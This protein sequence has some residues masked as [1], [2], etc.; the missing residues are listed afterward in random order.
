MS[1]T[2]PNPPNLATTITFEL[3]P[4]EDDDGWR[5]AA[6]FPGGR[7]EY[8]TGFMNRQ[9]AVDWMSSPQCLEWARARGH[10]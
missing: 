1:A 7:T 2:M 8:V 9:K 3:L 6:T 10:H 5:V 4:N